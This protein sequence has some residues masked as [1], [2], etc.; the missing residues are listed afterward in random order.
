MKENNCKK[1]DYFAENKQ[2]GLICLNPKSDNFNQK[3]ELNDSCEHIETN[4]YMHHQE[5]M[6]KQVCFNK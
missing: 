1:C 5:M 2:K 3:V 4:Y 6:M